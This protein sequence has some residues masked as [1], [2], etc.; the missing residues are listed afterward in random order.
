MDQP[1][2]ATT[3]ATRKM[4]IRDLVL[5][6]SIGVHAHEHA[7]P[8]R[9]RI[10]L[11]LTVTEDPAV[12]LSRPAIGRDD[13]SRVVDYEQIANRVRAIIA[14]GHVQLVETLAERIAEACLTDARVTLASVRV[15]KLDIFTDAA[16]VGVE[17]ERRNC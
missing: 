14:A 7:A 2:P 4:F 11:D 1:R 15:E 9:V 13:L 5:H 17:I 8:Q 16:S 3:R 10:N 12:N 6:A